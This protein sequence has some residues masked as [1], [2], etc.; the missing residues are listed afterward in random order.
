MN[1]SG[2]EWMGMGANGARGGGWSPVDAGL[3]EYI[4]VQEGLVGWECMQVDV[5]PC[6]WIPVDE[7]GCGWMEMGVN[8][9]NFFYFKF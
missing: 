2:W 7:S 5:S 6:D 9:C 8:C 3:C 4:Q 1:E